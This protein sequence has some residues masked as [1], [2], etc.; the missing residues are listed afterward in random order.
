LFRV[1][2]SNHAKG[3]PES[4]SPCGF[5]EARGGGMQPRASPRECGGFIHHKFRFPGYNPQK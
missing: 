1:Q 2:G 3:T 4:A 5:L